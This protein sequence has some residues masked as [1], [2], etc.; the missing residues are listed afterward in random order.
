MCPSV[1]SKI[2]PAFVVARRGTNPPDGNQLRRCTGALPF[3]KT[4]RRFHRMLSYAIRVIPA[5][6]G[7]LMT[8]APHFGNQ[9]TVF[10][11]RFPKVRFS[12][13]VCGVII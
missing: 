13:K 1:V 3:L 9:R 11:F 5:F 2:K 12:R 6:L 4:P 10:H 7:D 8:N